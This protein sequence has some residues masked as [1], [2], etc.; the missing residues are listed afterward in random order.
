MAIKIPKN[1]TITSKYTA[2]KEYM[3]VNSHANYQ[4]YYYELNGKLFAGKEFNQFAPELQKYK[5]SNVNILLTKASTFLFG[6]LS[7]MNI[8]D[9]TPT[10]SFFNPTQEEVIR[11]YSTRYFSKKLNTS[12]TVIKEIN[13]ES[14]ESLQVSS[15]YQV[16]SI[17]YNNIDATTGAFDTTQLNIAFSQMPDLKLFLNDEVES[18][19]RQGQKTLDTQN[20]IAS[21]E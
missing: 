19:R 11:G 12:P 10:S 16:V 8:N 20:I 3:V 4:G 13:Q 5:S 6:K 14:F 7:G 2:G 1:I 18:G 21:F 17:K 15:L 9:L